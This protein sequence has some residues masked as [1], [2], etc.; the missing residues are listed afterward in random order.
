MKRKVIFMT[1]KEKCSACGIN[2]HRPGQKTCK[3]CHA[4][5]MR[6]NRPKHSELTD[7]QRMKANCRSYANVAFKRGK[8]IKQPC[9]KCGD[10]NSEMHHEDY[11]KP[12]EVIWLCRKD[13]LGLHQKEQ[14]CER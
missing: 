6:K 7:A 10:E 2:D 8:L 4:E 12:L 13:H 1:R 9:V 14:N 5:Y 11:T 3:P